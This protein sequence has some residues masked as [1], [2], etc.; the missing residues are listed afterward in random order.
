MLVLFILGF[1]TQSHNLMALHLVKFLIAHT[2]L[3]R[4]KLISIFELGTTGSQDKT[5]E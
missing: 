2:W 4:V 3:Q 1:S 5:V